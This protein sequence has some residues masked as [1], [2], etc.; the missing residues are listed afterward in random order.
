MRALHLGADFVFA[1][2]PFFY[3]AAALGKYGGDHAA[4]LFIDDLKNNMVQL[5]A[6]TLAEIREGDLL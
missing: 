4:H 2:R 1:G 5:G 6:A 3:G